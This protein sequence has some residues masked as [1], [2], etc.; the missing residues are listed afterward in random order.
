MSR[1]IIQASPGA[2]WVAARIPEKHFP[3]FQE[4][5]EQAMSA[6]LEKYGYDEEVRTSFNETM[7]LVVVR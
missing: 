2:L 6:V 5:L 1:A 3:Q 7:P 4:E